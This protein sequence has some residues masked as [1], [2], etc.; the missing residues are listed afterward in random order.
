MNGSFGIRRVLANLGAATVARIGAAL[1]SMTLFWGLSHLLGATELGGFAL[2]MSLFA[3]LQGLPLL[4]LH[5]PLTREV[6]TRPGDLAER[7]AHHRWFAM[8]VALVLGLSLAAY[9][10]WAVEPSLYPALLAVAAA[11]LPTGATLVTETAL[12]GQERVRIVAAVS[13]AEG[14]WRLV[15]SLS[16]VALGGGLTGVAVAFLIGRCMAWG[17]Y[18]LWAGLPAPD[19]P[20]RSQARRPTAAQWRALWRQVP[21]YLGIVA[22]AALGA[23]LDVLALSRL[24]GLDEVA[25]YAVAARLYEAALM[26]PTLAAL[27]VLPPLSRQFNVDR[28]AFV[29]NVPRV[30]G[31]ILLWGLPIVIVGAGAMPWLIRLV[32]PPA[33]ADAAPMARVLLPA[34]LLAALDMILASWM[35]AARAQNADLRSLSWALLAMVV[36]LLVL[37]PRIGALGAA[38]AMLVQMV[39][40]V[41]SRAAWAR[42]TLRVQGLGPLLAGIA[43]AASIAMAVLLACE[44][45]QPMLAIPAAL[46]AYGVA[47]VCLGLSHP[48]QWR[49]ALRGMPSPW[50]RTP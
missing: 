13:V 24:V 32:F 21:V 8:P 15:A 11:M 7:L 31:G 48:A 45:W 44:R 16:A 42:Q 34:A 33:L 28:A 6:A 27:V 43:L 39:V 41:V 30:V 35:Q 14:A 22:V 49:T 29:A 3:L 19:G 12:I 46:I 18:R 25:R 10:R 47:I 17:L 38:I 1:L 26:L 2:L 40:R 50:T 20:G 37:V 36:T 23:R 4:G 5:V 9:G